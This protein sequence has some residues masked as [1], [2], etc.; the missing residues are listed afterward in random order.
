MTEKKGGGLRFNDGKLRYD[1]EHPLARRDLID[2]ITYGANKYSILDEKGKIISK[3]DRNWE[4]GMEWTKVIASSKRHLAAI[5]NGEDFD[6][7]PHCSGCVNGNCQKH[8][9]LLHVS[10]LQANAHFLNA[11][12]YIY[13]QGDN[14]KKLN[15]NLP[16]IALDVDEVLADWVGG[17]QEMFNLNK[18]PTSW[19]FDRHIMDKFDNLIK[20]NK[21]DDFYLS[22]KPLISESEIPFEPT[23]Y[24]TSR[25]VSTKITEMWL[26]KN[27]FPAKPVYTVETGKSKVEVLKEQNI[28]VFIDDS[29]ENF[30]E[31]NN[32][33]ILCYLFDQPHN[34]RYNV[35]HLRLKSLKNLPFF[36]KFDANI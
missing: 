18:R 36:G 15:L 25:P 30:L 5:E 2:V 22:L 16:R 10:H 1:L 34:Q 9:G 24:V 21:L 32:S 23:C 11:Y 26:D 6:Y 13:P 33:G 3:G 8:S 28:E 14:R 4:L 27:N 35:G 20:N 7:D 29:Y 12:Y 17:W 31:I 19:F